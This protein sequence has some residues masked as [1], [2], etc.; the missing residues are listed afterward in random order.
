[1]EA[2]PEGRITPDDLGIW[3]DEHAKAL[4][5]VAGFIRQQG[6]VAA[7]QLAHAGRRASTAAPW[8]GGGPV[9]PAERGWQTVGPSPIPFDEGYPEPREL[10]REGLALVLQQFEDAAGRS[11]AAGF[12]VAEVHMA[13][14]YLLHE[15]LS[16]LSNRRGDEYGGVLEN[17]MRFPLEVAAAVRKA[18][19]DD[20]P[21]FVRISATDWAEGAG[22][23]SSRSASATS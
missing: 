11:L 1:L 8:N 21:L 10:S 16:P 19:P 2:A 4:R 20:L 3:S 17:R 22:T 13:H 18:W 14:G 12:Q 6:S 5:K 9:G 7:I 23:S 15:F